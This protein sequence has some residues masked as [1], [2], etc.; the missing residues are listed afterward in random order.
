MNLKYHR[1]VTSSRRGLVTIDRQHLSKSRPERTLIKRIARTG[2][3]NNYGRVTA[4]QRGGGARKLYRM[5][6]FRRQKHDAPAMVEGIE[7]DPNRS[8]FIALVEREGAK[9][10]VIA[11]ESIKAGDR[12]GG[13]EIA[14][15]TCMQLS[16][17][18]SGTR[19]HNIEFRPGVGARAVR[20][21]GTSAQILGV[22]GDLVAVRLPSGNIRKLSKQ[23]T[24]VIGVVSNAA[25][26]NIN[27]AKAGRSRWKGWRPHVRATA[28]NSRDCRG[29]GGR[30][31]SKGS[32][33]V[34]PWGQK[35][36]GLKTRRPSKPKL[37]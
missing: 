18:P 6:D 17:I 7:Y 36:K 19:V 30:G 5:V 14:P 20:S 11:P 21:A 37:S 22:D 26:M 35:A 28:T 34:S 8:A 25:H 13:G 12:I 31:R 3:R 29:G 15:G 9:S 33:P 32:H 27:D 23:C 24:A 10:Y 1:P 2:G 4:W 16:E